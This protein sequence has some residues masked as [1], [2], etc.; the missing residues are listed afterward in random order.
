MN[1]L[2]DGRYGARIDLTIFRRSLDTSGSIIC[3]KWTRQRC[4]AAAGNAV[5]SALLQPQAGPESSSPLSPPGTF[6]AA[7]TR[8]RSPGTCNLPTPDRG[9]SL[10]VGSSTEGEHFG[11]ANVPGLDPAFYEAAARNP[12]LVRRRVRGEVP[13]A[14]RAGLAVQV[15]ADP[16]Y[17]GPGNSPPVPRL[18]SLV[19]I[20]SVEALALTPYQG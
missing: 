11:L 15:P 5:L 18:E 17:R 8:L 7:A 19:S 2:G 3:L 6:G 12:T 9:F 13:M 14:E 10:H 4:L 1:G 20:L 16:E